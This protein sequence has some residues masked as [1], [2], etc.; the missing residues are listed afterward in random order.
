MTIRRNAFSI[1]TDGSME[2]NKQIK[3][4][5]KV[6]RQKATHGGPILQLGVTPG[7]RKLYH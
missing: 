1:Y 5:V 4:E 7:G 3:Q 2:Q 6:I